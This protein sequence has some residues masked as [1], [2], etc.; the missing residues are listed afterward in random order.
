MDFISVA[1]DTNDPLQG[2]DILSVASLECLQVSLSNQSSRY[3]PVFRI[4][5][6]RQRDEREDIRQELMGCYHAHRAGSAGRTPTSVEKM[7]EVNRSF[8]SP[9][10]LERKMEGEVR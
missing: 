6:N 8:L 7:R 4:C 5:Y 1:V 9:Y 3:E 10:I 2:L